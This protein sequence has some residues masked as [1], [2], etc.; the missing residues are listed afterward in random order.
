MN[1]SISPSMAGAFTAT[2]NT[3]ISSSSCISQEAFIKLGKGNAPELDYQ[4][5]QSTCF[6]VNSNTPIDLPDDYF[7]PE[8]FIEPK[9]HFWNRTLNLGEMQIRQ[10]LQDQ[11]KGVAGPGVVSGF[12]TVT[13]RTPLLV[14]KGLAAGHLL[15]LKNTGDSGGLLE[16]KSGDAII[17]Q[18]QKGN[19]PISTR[20]LYG[21]QVVRYLPKPKNPNPQLYIVLKYSVCS[22]LGAYGAGKTLKTM[23][24]LPGEKT[25]ISIR[26]F[27]HSDSTRTKAENILDSFSESSTKELESTIQE[28]SGSTGTDSNVLNKGWNLGGSVDVTIPV[29]G[30]DIP[31]NLTGGYKRDRTISHIADETEKTIESALD[32]T[33]SISSSVREIAINTTTQETLIQEKEE[34]IVREIQ[35]INDSRVLNFVFRQL[36]QEY[37]TVTFLNDVRIVYSNGYPESFQ[38]TGLEG[39]D[40][41]LESVLND[42]NQ[43]AHVREGIILQLCNL[44]DH[45]GTRRSFAERVQDFMIDC[46]GNQVAPIEYFRKRA[47]LKDTFTSGDLSIEVPGIIKSISRRVLRTDSVIADALLGQGEALDCYNQRLQDAAAIKA[48]LETDE[49]AQ[50]IALLEEITDPVQRAELYKRVFG[51]CCDTI[52]TQIIN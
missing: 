35:N 4:V 41:L 12:G 9:N 42:S 47:D 29:K 16:L 25:T 39:I 34:S 31:V 49:L 26:T 3:T 14:E 52:Q 6:G 27:K 17:E 18:I 23:S 44:F 43:V 7:K 51:D 32:R 24:L 11:I 40:S 15:D 37:I 50:K 46:D 8:C 38:S 10:E 21:D 2:A 28:E 13:P 22:Y 48:N 33:V 20:N 19:R 36:L 1:K 5:P 45:T 30:V